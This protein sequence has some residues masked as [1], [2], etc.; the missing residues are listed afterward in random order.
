MNHSFALTPGE[1]LSAKSIPFSAFEHVPIRTLDDIERELA[2]PPELL[3]KTMAFRVAD[4][5]LVL[6]ALPI[7]SRVHYGRLARS[8]N[9]SRSLLRQA[10]E[11]D[12]QELGMEPGGVSPLTRLP[13]VVVVFDS[14]VQRMDTVYCGSGRADATI[15]IKAGD[16][17]AAVDARFAEIAH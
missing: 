4:S 2:L 5:H 13:G 15:K 17:A 1:I 7:L 3:L 16:L 14:A 12:L 10:E 8:V 6:A 9:V 11:A